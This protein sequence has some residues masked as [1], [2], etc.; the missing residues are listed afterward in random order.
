MLPNEP[1]E[2]ERRLTAGAF[3]NAIHRILTEPDLDE[4][5][6]FASQM[7]DAASQDATLKQILERGSRLGRSR[8]WVARQFP[9]GRLHAGVVA[10]KGE[11]LLTLAGSPPAA[12]SQ[13]DT[14]AISEANAVVS[15][16]STL[17]FRCEPEVR[18]LPLELVLV[19][20]PRVTR[21]EFDELI[22][23]EKPKVAPAPREKFNRSDRT[24]AMALDIPL[25]GEAPDPIEVDSI[26]GTFEVVVN[27]ASSQLEVSTER[28]EGEDGIL[29]A[30]VQFDGGLP[31]PV[32]LECD[33]SDRQ[34]LR[35]TVP[36]PQGI[37][38]GR[39]KAAIVVVHE[40]TPDELPLLNPTEASLWLA[41]QHA[42]V[43]PLSE[44]RSGFDFTLDE[45][46]RRFLAE[47]TDAIV[48]VR[49]EPQTSEVGR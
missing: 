48:A 32:I 26:V 14:A 17:Q 12:N 46:D 43:I 44:D 9:A 27:L 39:E 49:I 25:P 42:M 21:V 3:D 8:L 28:L 13:E 1:G 45:G 22:G 7:P 35:G 20:E 47:N 6:E 34:T 5:D 38:E 30:T 37:R 2:F 11:L 4:D 36:L 31:I 23:F 18:G 19:V 29:I 10:G 40:V 41:G 33:E 15:F 16:G 24:P